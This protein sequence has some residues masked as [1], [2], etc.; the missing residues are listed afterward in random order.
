[1]NTRSIALLLVALAASAA[2]VAAKEK[3]KAEI[4][5]KVRGRGKRGRQSRGRW[6]FSLASARALRVSSKTSARACPA[7]ALREAAAPIHSLSLPRPS[8]SQHTTIAGLLRRGDRRQG[9]G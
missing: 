8:K 6:F 3:K 7:R 2:V 4:T 5:H 9:R 1:M